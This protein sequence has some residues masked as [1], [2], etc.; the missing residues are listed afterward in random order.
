MTI[1]F[2]VDYIAY[3]FTQQTLLKLTLDSRLSAKCWEATTLVLEL[4]RFTEET[5]RE[6]GKFESKNNDNSI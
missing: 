4:F 3:S 5:G 6:I 2:V 1:T